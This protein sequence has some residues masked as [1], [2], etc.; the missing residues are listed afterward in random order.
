MDQGMSSKDT[1]AVLGTGI[2]GA[3]MARNLLAAGFP[4]RAWNRTAEKAAPLADAGAVVAGSP[5]R[6]GRGR[7]RRPHDAHRRRRRA[8]DR[9]RRARRR[10]GVGADVDRRASTAPSAARRWR[11]SA[12]STFVDAPVLGSRQPAEEGKLMV[13]AS[14]PE[15]VRERVDPAVRRG[16]RAHVVAGGGRLRPAAQAR[17]QH[18]GGRAR[19]GRGGDAPA[20][21]GT[22][23]A[24]AVVPRPDRGRCRW[25]PATRSSRARA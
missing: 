5:A 8:R 15:D 2:M 7:R 22:R 12:A 6:G 14:G 10:H 4:V 25:T 16:R 20:G 23:R 9:R 1:V 17:R 11:P 19:R 13:L 3:P 24:A 21:G 18:L